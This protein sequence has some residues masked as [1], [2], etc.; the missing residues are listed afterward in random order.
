MAKYL[1]YFT[2][3]CADDREFV[4]A[5]AP[6]SFSLNMPFDLFEYRVKKIPS[7]GITKLVVS[8][9]RNQKQHLQQEL[10]NVLVVS[11]F[12]D[13]PAWQALTPLAQRKYVLDSI[14]TTLNATQNY[15]WKPSDYEPVY[16]AI[17]DEGIVFADFWKKP[18][19]SPN[20]ELSA[21]LRFEYESEIDIWLVV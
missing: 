3:T 5:F 10:L 21:Q 14:V 7:S 6:G 9:T 12:V 18:V 8:Y 20:R 13:L 4:Q 15:G 17:V 16:R 1:R 11:F 19:R 2:S